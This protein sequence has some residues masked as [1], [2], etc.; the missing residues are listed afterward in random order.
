MMSSPGALWS[1]L[2][3]VAAQKLSVFLDGLL[4]V[5][6]FPLRNSGLC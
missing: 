1:R 5:P 6:E 4:L 2:W 3:L